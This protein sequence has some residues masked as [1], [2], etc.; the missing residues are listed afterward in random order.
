MDA[1]KFGFKYWKKY[2][3]A[4]VILQIVSFL[5]IIADLLIPFVSELFVDFVIMDNDSEA[6]GVFAFLIDGDYGKRHSFELFFNIAF[7]FL[8]LLVF[9]LIFIY[10]KSNQIID[11]FFVFRKENS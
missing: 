10:I 7:V 4:A 3:V 2:I 1:I 11:C 5:A 6:S 9:R 8:A